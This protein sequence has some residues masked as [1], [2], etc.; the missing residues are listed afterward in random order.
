MSEPRTL[1]SKRLRALLWQAAEGKCQRCG[2]DLD[3]LWQADEVVP[4]R[5]THRTNVHEMQA[6]CADCNRRK[7]AMELRRFQRELL[8]VCRA[9][10]DRSRSGIKLL[11]LD[12]AAGTGKSNGPV[13]LAE[14]L[15][16]TV[17][18]ANCW[19]APRTNLPA[20]G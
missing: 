8:D 2:C 3:E 11:V 6:L 7:G 1:R 4:W 16:P 15:I 13:I 18:D 20:V 10:K 9:I 17:F 14:E 5:K 19:V 12:C